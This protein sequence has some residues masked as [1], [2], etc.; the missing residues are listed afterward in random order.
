MTTVDDQLVD[1]TWRAAD[2]TR[3][4]LMRDRAAVESCLAGLDADRLEWVL[5]WLVLDHDALFTELGEPSMGV[6]SLDVVAALAPLEVEF[7]V[8]TAV[9]RV[10]SGESGLGT[11]IAG[12]ALPEQIHAITVSTA[13]ML[14][15]A[16]G[17]A[18]ALDRI[19]QQARQ[20]VN[21]GHPRPYPTP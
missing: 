21:A 9:H 19:D 20:C 8:T 15:E 14:L 18:G 16:L 17:L 4:Y 1:A 11:A 6:G 5:A 7:A 12:L 2:L 13:V 10:A 3:A